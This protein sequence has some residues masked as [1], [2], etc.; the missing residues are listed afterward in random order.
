MSKTLRD[1][2]IVGVLF[3]ALWLPR[4]LALDSYVSADERKWL[5]RSPFAW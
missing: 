4:T 3:L 2:L 5:T 1:V